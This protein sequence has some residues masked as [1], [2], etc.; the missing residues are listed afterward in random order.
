MVLDMTG[1]G[2]DW[3]ARHSAAAA[4]ERDGWERLHE[5]Y[6]IDWDAAYT[7]AFVRFAVS[8]GWSRE[9]AESWPSNIADKARMYASEHDYCPVR[10]ARADVVACEEE[11]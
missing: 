6:K 3:P 7:A 5:A 11:A 4:T 9:N 8:R 2:I 1:A 10:T